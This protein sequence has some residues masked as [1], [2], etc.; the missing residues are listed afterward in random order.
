MS[1]AVDARLFPTFDSIES[2]LWP[3]LALAVFVVTA[4]LVDVMIILATRW[5]ILDLPSRRSAHSLPTARAGGVPMVATSVI[6]SAMVCARWPDATVP[7]LC[8]LIGPALIVAAVGF[9]DDIRPLRALLRLFIQIGVAVAVVAVLGPLRSVVFPGIG[10]LD[11]G[12]AAWPLSLVWVVGMINAYNFMDGSDGMAATGA[13]VITTF[14]CGLGFLVG[15]PVLVLVPAFLGAAAAG[16]LVFNWA[17]ARVFMG[18]VGS[19][20]LGAALAALALVPDGASRA[21]VFLPMLMAMWPYIFDPFLTVLRRV[22]AGQN[23]LVPH[24]EFL[25]HRLVR[26]GW[27]HPSVALL[28]AALA[29]AGG[30]AGRLLLSDSVPPEVRRWLPFVVPVMAAGLVAYVDHH[31]RRSPAGALSRAAASAPGLAVAPEAAKAE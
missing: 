30:L 31:F 21:Q 15:S 23:P 4:I 2:V 3:G 28:Y 20:Y 27:S 14:L 29:V 5:H 12:P 16:F 13:I 9:V 22:A 7:V 18:D 10:T 1:D 17:P 26:A 8:G 25:F 24:R 19:A 6:A 11:L